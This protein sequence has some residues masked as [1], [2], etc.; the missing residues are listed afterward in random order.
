MVCGRTQNLRASLPFHH[1]RDEPGVVGVG[2][3]DHHGV[4]PLM[5][6]FLDVIRARTGDV[7]LRLESGIHQDARVTR[8]DEQRAAADMVRAAHRGD[9]QAAGPHLRGDGALRLPG[10]LRS[11]RPARP[12]LRPYRGSTA[13]AAMPR[14]HPG[15]GLAAAGGSCP[16]TIW[17]AVCALGAAPPPRARPAARAACAAASVVPQVGLKPRAAACFGVQLVLRAPER[18]LGFRQELAKLTRLRAPRGC[19]RDPGCASAQQPCRTERRQKPAPRARG[20]R[21]PGAAG[22]RQLPPRARPAQ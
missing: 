21:G 18:G 9:G 4:D 1:P 15:S 7:R 10:Y 12:A 3:R 20:G 2:V 22:R 11:C 16:A 17:H 14:A 13:R 8:L 5:H 6:G 19:A